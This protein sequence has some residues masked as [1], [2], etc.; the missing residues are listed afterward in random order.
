MTP[1]FASDGFVTL[2]VIG[3]IALI[4]MLWSARLRGQ[5]ERRCVGNATA[6]DLAWVRIVACG[7]LILYIVLTENLSSQARLDA[8]FFE[9]PG[10]LMYLQR[11]ALGFFV[12]S[13]PHLKLLT[14]VLVGVLVLAAVGLATR[15]TIPL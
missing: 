12:T 4:A 10:Y 2:H 6:I 11:G 13:A 8:T 5:F 14:G 1:I 3:I 9:W 7:V 15:I